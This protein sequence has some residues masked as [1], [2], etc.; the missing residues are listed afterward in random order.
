[1][2]KSIYELDLHER[3]PEQKDGYQSYHIHRVPGGWIY[4]FSK[5]SVFVPYDNEFEVSNPINEP[6]YIVDRNGT[7]IIGDLMKKIESYETSLM[8]IAY[9]DLSGCDS[10]YIA[11]KAL[12]KHG[13]IMP[14]LDT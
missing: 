5:S 4:E 3:N 10:T 6:K 2:S 14:L 8:K 12:E 1:M 13:I 7:A 11:N 9:R